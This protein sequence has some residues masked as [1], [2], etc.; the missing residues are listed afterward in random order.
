MTTEY[1]LNKDSSEHQA[2]LDS[3]L[4][5]HESSKVVNL[6]NSI[7]TE[8][9][10]V[11]DFDETL[12]L[13]NSTEAYLD[14][15]QPRILGALLLIMLDRVKPWSWLPKQF[16]PKKTRDWMR[17][18]IATILFPWTVL[19]WRIRAK[20][21]AQ[22]YENTELI[23]AIKSNPNL[24]PVIVSYGFNFIVKPI[25]KSLPLAINQVIA[26]RFWRGIFDRQ[27]G[28][29]VLIKR[30]LKSEDLREC[31][32]VTD[33]LDDATLLSIA[34][35]PCLTKWS[36]A[37]YIPAMSN[38]YLPI[39]YYERVKRPGE[40]PFLNT[41]IKNHLITLV[42]ALS[43]LSSAPIIHSVSMFFLTLA[44]WC[45]Y[46]IGYF[47]NDQ[48]AERYEKKPNLSETYQRYKARMGMWQ[49]WI[50]SIAFSL[51]GLIFL[52]VSEQSVWS[53]NH[54]Q[55]ITVKTDLNLQHL[56]LQFSI[57]FSVLLLTRIAFWIYNYLD[58]KS[59]TWLYPVLQICKYFG[60]A[61]VSP[62]NLIGSILLFTQVLVEWVPYLIYRCADVKYDI[63][64][65][66][67]FRVVTFICLTVSL[68]T[69]QHEISIA[70]NSQFL[71]IL[72]W[73]FLRSRSQFKGVIDNAYPIWRDST[74]CKV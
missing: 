21:I 1:C 22:A 27:V 36:E 35:Y 66:K 60:F 39:F 61:A 71:V 9:L 51:I 24:K 20:K 69:A 7:S 33:S 43:W 47:E 5:E 40:S 74:N 29:E 37:I 26:C 54:P 28:K 63:F 68:A 15:L 49:P 45:I 14:T 2:S 59:R 44:F 57:W 53:L 10:A 30:Q 52:E 67:V 48:I 65:H 62:T 73:C 6:L 17:V 70:V 18:L 32:V 3:E 72:L 25:A 38:V 12:L 56:L 46:E 55:N 23:Q 31:I 42:L 58:K 13:R 8:T 50:W 19:L 16:C 11:L 64:Q 4:P 41:I 34:R